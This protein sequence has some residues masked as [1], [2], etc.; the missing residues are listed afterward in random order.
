MHF[1]LLMVPVTAGL[2]N[3]RSFVLGIDYKT[4]QIGV[5]GLKILFFL[6]GN[7]YCLVK[8]IDSSVSSDHSPWAWFRNRASGPVGQ[9]L[10]NQR[11]NK[12]VGFPPLPSRGCGRT[13]V[14]A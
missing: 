4:E 12:G 5:T 14:R 7:N 1:D 11:L 9:E 3:N 6:C 2:L 8:Q 13:R 10:P